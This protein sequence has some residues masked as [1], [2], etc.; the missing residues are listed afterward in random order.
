MVMDKLTKGLRAPIFP[1]VGELFF[2]QTSDRM[3]A[4]VSARDQRYAAPPW[5]GDPRAAIIRAIVDADRQH[6]AI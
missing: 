5:E 2:N 6:P 3:S 1:R 4:G